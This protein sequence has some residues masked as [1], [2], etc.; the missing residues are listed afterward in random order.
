MVL[1]IDDREDLHESFRKTFKNMEI[2]L[3]L[4]CF[5]N[6]KDLKAEIDSLKNSGKIHLLKSLIV[7]LS[8]SKNEEENK[9][10]AVGEIINDSF[11]NNSIPIFIHSGFLDYYKDFSDF[12]SV[13]KVKKT[14]ESV[15]EVCRQISLMLN[16]G[17][18]GIFTKDGILQRSFAKQIHEAFIEQFKGAEICQI[19][20]SISSANN[21]SI[22]DFKSRTEEVFTRIAIRSLYQNLI[23]A[24][25]FEESDSVQETK[26][27]VVEHYY[28]RRSDFK[29]WTGDIFENLEDGSQVMILTPRCDI[30]NNNCKDKFLVCS[31]SELDSSLKREI[32]KEPNKF[33]TD[34]PTK[35]GIK[36]RFL[37]PAP[38]YRGGKVDL[39]D[40]FQ[41]AASELTGQKASYQMLIS[42]SDELTNEI[43]R[44]FAS[45]ILRGGVSTA[46][47]SEASFY[48]MEAKQ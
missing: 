22:E 20:S 26:I 46:E 40:Y 36:S 4:K 14:A 11:Y 37:I 44:K 25:K 10:F 17:F 31:I 5:N 47:L 45:Y 8:N 42:L 9:Q 33:L 41:L 27:N 29:I 18:L 16:S 1:L 19:I 24:K 15:V 35:S 21:K 48:S 7:D 39:T 34:N 30:N 2:N 32:T 23:G 38:N 12:G 13:I 28:R 3:D 43:V 6:V